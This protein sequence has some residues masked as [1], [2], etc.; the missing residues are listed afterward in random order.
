MQEYHLEKNKQRKDELV[1][2]SKELSDLLLN[3]NINVREAE[4]ILKRISMDIRHTKIQ[5]FIYP[6]S[7]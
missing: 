6:E 3:R 1:L 5:E 4:W 7:V 2:I